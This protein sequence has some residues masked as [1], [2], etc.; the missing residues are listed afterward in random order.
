MSR[1][2]ADE[3]R[4]LLTRTPKGVGDWGHRRAVDF[5]EAHRSASR[6]LK[7]PMTTPWMFERHLFALRK[8]HESA[9]EQA[10]A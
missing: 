3:L 10:K 2:F 4:E 9:P 6:A 8:F 1:I 5:K 7:N